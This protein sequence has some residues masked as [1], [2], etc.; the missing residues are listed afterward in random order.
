MRIIIEN[1]ELRMENILNSTLLI[2][3]HF[4][5]LR[6]SLFS[7]LH[8]QFSIKK[9]QFKKSPHQ[10]VSMKKLLTASAL[11]FAFM[12]ILLSLLTTGII[13][14]NKED[15]DIPVPPEDKSCSS[16][17][18]TSSSSDEI[19]S[20]SEIAFSSAF[21]ESSSS[22]EASSSSEEVSSSSLETSSS[23][24]EISSSSEE[25]SSSSLEISSSSEA[26]IY[27][28]CDG[29]PYEALTHFCYSNDNKIYELCGSEK[30]KYDVA[31]QSCVAGL[32]KTNCGSGSYEP[33]THFCQSGNTPTELCGGKTYTAAQFC[34]AG[35]VIDKCG[36][37]E[38]N[39]AT[40]NCCGANTLYLS[41]TQF[42]LNNAVYNKCGSAEY[43]PATQRCG[44][45]N[46][47][48]TSCG[49]GWYNAANSDLRCQS[50]VV[51]TKC[52]SEW[53]NAANSNLMCHNGLLLTQ[54]G[55]DW[56]NAA[57]SNQRCQSNIV[58][59]KCGSEW[60]NA[61]NSNLRC[62]SNVIET[63]CGTGW[64]NAATQF[65]SNNA[66]YDRCGGGAEYN[67]ATQ[68]CFKNKAIVNKCGGSEYTLGSQGCCV[69]EIY[70]VVNRSCIDDKIYYRCALTNTWYN[71]ST[72]F[73]SNS[74]IYNKCG[75]A[76]YNPAT[77]YCSNG[78]LRT[79]GTFTYSGQTYKTIVIGTQIWMAENL[80]YNASGS[81]CYNNDASNCAKYGRLYEW[82]TAKSVCPTGWHLPS[83]AEW[84]T[85]TNFVGGESTAGMKLKA[86]SGWNNGGNGTDAYGFSALPGGNRHF[87]IGGDFYNVG[88]GGYWWSTTEYNASRAL[89]WG[90]GYSN[91]FVRSFNDAKSSLISVRCVIN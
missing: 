24:E 31:T 26:K 34:N 81:V 46:L 71:P 57:S 40:Q 14:C 33:S 52:G 25:V 69:N 45:G 53:Y 43:N 1:G 60:Y 64:Y 5:S 62:Q 48:E 32:I 8:S 4:Q 56:Y 12:S 61:A 47:V 87:G 29:K 35:N 36:G 27:D 72:Q 74:K 23:S 58:E 38:Y 28:Y 83:D 82:A 50:N 6:D 3:Q 67:P 20:S 88:N 85:L 90:M 18:E 59:T 73:C 65:C 66:V 44:A 76:E 54:C 17:L 13:S 75:S 55:T 70:N 37:N 39:P 86:A 91:E 77:Q 15:P 30:K 41:S 63:K 22:E 89:A 78:T 10:E 21:E 51:E 84:T 9:S 2:V 79:Y 16:S 19:S 49:T 42:C 80:N 11:R 68:F 7:I